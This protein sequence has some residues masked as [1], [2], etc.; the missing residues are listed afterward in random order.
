MLQL[1]RQSASSRRALSSLAAALT[2]C[3]LLHGVHGSDA[4]MSTFTPCRASSR[5]SR[6]TLIALAL[7]R[8]SSR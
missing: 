8:M 6:R 5:I 2:Y 4:Q 7:T 1:P 3:Q